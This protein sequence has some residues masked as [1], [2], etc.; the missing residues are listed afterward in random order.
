MIDWKPIETAPKNETLVLLYFPSGNEGE[1]RYKV[2][3]WSTNGNDWFDS[4]AA[5][6]PLTAWGDKP[7]H[8]AA[9]YAP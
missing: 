6:N 1:D 8:W 9:L 7:S 3:F 5:S 2:G 4:E